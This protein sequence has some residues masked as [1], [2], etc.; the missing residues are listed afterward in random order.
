MKKKRNNAKVLVNILSVLFILF[1]LLELQIMFNY[2][3]QF[4]W[5][6]GIGA[7]IL[8]DVYFLVSVAVN[9]KNAAQEDKEE[10]FKN[11]A[12]SEKAS[13]LL[14]KKC[15]QDL[16]ERMSRL[17][18]KVDPISSAVAENEIKVQRGL[19]QSITDNKKV[20]KILIGKTKENADAVMN[21][22]V[23]LRKLLKGFE[24][25]LSDMEER[26][27]ELHT[28]SQGSGMSMDQYQEILSSIQSLEQSIQGQEEQMRG[29]EE[30]EQLFPEDMELM[31]DL[32]ME[33]ES[34]FMED[35]E[36]FPESGLEEDSEPIFDTEL[37]PEL[38]LEEEQESMEL[39]E[40]ELG[41]EPEPELM[42]LPEPELGLEPELEPMELSEPELGFEPELE[43]IP[44]PEPELGLEP[45]LEPIPI[46]EPEL[47]PEPEPKPKPMSA[48][49]SLQRMKLEA[50]K[51]E[52]AS[53]AKVSDPNKV[54]SPEEIAALI[55]NM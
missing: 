14:M 32:T 46:P 45:E 48:L 28:S 44:I 23:E 37:T 51:K 9:Q 40:S 10:Q 3:D 53:G 29:H 11:I 27:E 54:M 2:P 15:F 6:V 1:V 30:A 12:T 33:P 20:A 38:G 39:S 7:L 21:S 4:V 50:E 25:K 42:E 55:A 36:L 22:N 49:Q 47:S 5:F 16:E 43:P 24:Q 35:G 52:A 8:V 41:F 13:Y 26:M 17:E 18:E 34:E 19:S 31:P